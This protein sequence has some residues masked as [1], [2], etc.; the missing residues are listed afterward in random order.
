MVPKVMKFL[1]ILEKAGTNRFGFLRALARLRDNELARRAR[2]KG[3]GTI[4][5]SIL[6]PEEEAFSIAYRVFQELVPVMDAELGF[7][8]FDPSNDVRL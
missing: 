1:Q 6:D 4:S 8:H 7:P 5:E 3:T 2:F